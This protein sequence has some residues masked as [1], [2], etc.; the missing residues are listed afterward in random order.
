MYKEERIYAKSLLLLNACYF[1]PALTT[2]GS[3][4][5]SRSVL[6]VD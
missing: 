4:K 3:S 6:Q 5:M 2:F 1:V